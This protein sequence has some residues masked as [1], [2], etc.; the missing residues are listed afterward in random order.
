[1]NPGYKWLT[2]YFCIKLSCMTKSLKLPNCS[3][4][5]IFDAS[6]L[7]CRPCPANASMITSYNGK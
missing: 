1:M 3:N 4:V 6:S 2:F 5:E 7:N